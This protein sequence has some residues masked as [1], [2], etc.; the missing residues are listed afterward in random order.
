MDSRT[1]KSARQCYSIRIRIASTT[2]LPK[3]SVGKLHVLPGHLLSVYTI[4]NLVQLSGCED[5]HCTYVSA[6]AHA[7]VMVV[8]S[9][10][11]PR[12]G[13]IT[14]EHDTGAVADI[15]AGDIGLLLLLLLLHMHS[16][17][18]IGEIVRNISGH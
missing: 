7:A 13:F 4:F 8:S 3:A 6:G 10:T 12:K 16:S 15:S 9:R 14:G 5:R 2:R 11:C 18:T 1:A 17:R